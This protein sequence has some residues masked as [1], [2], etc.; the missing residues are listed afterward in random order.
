MVYLVLSHMNV[1]R[2][3][4]YA[5]RL[6]IP[7]WDLSEVI[8]REVDLVSGYQPLSALC[9]PRSQVAAG[10]NQGRLTLFMVS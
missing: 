10:R 7:N 1:M 2:I 4:P 5:L 3:H 9:I 8:N 6:V